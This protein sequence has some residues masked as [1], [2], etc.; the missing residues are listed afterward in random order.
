MPTNKQSVESIEQSGG[1]PRLADKMTKFKNL[2]VSKAKD[3]D[4]KEGATIAE[5]EQ[6]GRVVARAVYQKGHAKGQMDHVE[7]GGTQDA[8]SIGATAKA[9]STAGIKKGNVV[10]TS[11]TQTADSATKDGRSVIEGNLGAVS[12]GC[13]AE[14]P[15]QNQNA[16]PMPGKSKEVA[17]KDPKQGKPDKSLSSMGKQSD[18]KTPLAKAEPMTPV[19]VRIHDKAN[20]IRYTH[21]FAS[22]QGAGDWL[23]SMGYRFEGKNP[24][25]E[26]V[27]SHKI[28]E[29]AYMNEYSPT[30]KPTRIN[31]SEEAP[32]HPD[33]A[34]A[35][36]N[37]GSAQKPPRQVWK[38]DVDTPAKRLSMMSRL[39]QHRL[40]N[41]EGNP[42][43]LDKGD[44]VPFKKPETKPAPKEDAKVEDNKDN[45][46][47]KEDQ[48]AAEKAA[49]RANTERIRLERAKANKGVLRSYRLKNSDEKNHNHD[50]KKSGFDRLLSKGDWK[51]PGLVPPTHPNPNPVLKKDTDW[52]VPGMVPPTHRSDVLK[53]GDDI[54]ANIKQLHDANGGSTY[55]LHHGNMFGQDR[56]AVAVQPE[57]SEII[58][59]ELTPEH[60]RGF[61]DRNRDELENPETAI[62]TWFDPQEKHHVLDIVALHPKQ[63]D[64]IELGRKHNQKAIFHLGSGSVMEL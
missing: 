61:I 50:L 33:A 27:Y 14:K 51:V 15:E 18:A 60:I 28:G 23:V 1:R 30:S 59:G 20:K 31:K 48:F 25:G 47:K 4:R 36:K 40:M 37:V 35:P 64:A 43:S 12:E 6:H 13:G 17:P 34:L 32:Q 42:A 49:N 62:G 46:Q 8:Q 56:W 52:K 38:R 29:R 21:H 39:A 10:N 63:A 54:V 2:I 7:V 16:K 57:R 41:Q 9:A 22:A 5:A 55:S 53:K 26:K 11:A 19:Y 24:I 3:P 45:D 58:K 44:V